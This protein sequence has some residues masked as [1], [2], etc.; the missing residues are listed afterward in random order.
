MNSKQT[1]KNT[2]STSSSNLIQNSSSKNKISKFSSNKV[3]SNNDININKKKLA[4]VNSPIKVTDK[5]NSN[6]KDKD[7]SKDNSIIIQSNLINIENIEISSYNSDPYIIPKKKYDHNLYITKIESTVNNYNKIKENLSKKILDNKIPKKLQSMQIKIFALLEELD[8]LSTILDTLVE[9][10][11]Y[12]PRNNSKDNNN[13]VEKEKDKNL[14][15]KEDKNK[16]TKLDINKKLLQNFE[17]QYN[18]LSEKYSKLSNEEYIK[19]LKNEQTTLSLEISKIEDDNKDLKNSQINNEYKIKKINI[20]VNDSEYKDKMTIYQRYENEYNSI[21]K[22]I[23]PMEESIKYYEERIS[24]LN[25]EKEALI[26]K[27]KE[28]Y[29]IDNPEKKCKKKDNEDISKNY[30]KKRELEFTNITKKSKVQKYEYQKKENGKYIKQLIDDK[31]TSTSLLKEKTELLKKL[32]KNLDDLELENRNLETNQIYQNNKKNNNNLNSNSNINN[33]NVNNSNEK[34]SSQNK[35]FITPIKSQDNNAYEKINNNISKINNRYDSTAKNNNSQ[36]YNKKMVLENIKLQSHQENL[37]KMDK[38]I[39]LKKNNKLKPNFSFTLNDINS[40]TKDKKVNLSVALQ[41]NKNINIEKNE[42]EGEEEIKE[43]IQI[44]SNINE[45]KKEEEQNIINLSQNEENDVGKIRE[46]DLNT[47]AYKE[48]DI[49]KEENK[50]N[51]KF[52]N[53]DE[54]ENDYENEEF[55]MEDNQNINMD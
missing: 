8:K 7:S 53:S 22:K 43:D 11:R 1:S 17:K 41:P 37:L 42:N 52:N 14:G 19:N 48:F 54:Q 25:K 12:V 2:K 34:A 23:T 24:I 32:N 45:D 35:S 5:N 6:L 33:S 13:K 9:K 39:N 44:N 16:P 18:I 38:S 29:N 36:T 28:K 21:R 20:S 15:K 51:F 49:K 50:S 30:L 31:M 10:K 40:N 26:K 55:N 46:N 47:V 3:K 27:A 4:K